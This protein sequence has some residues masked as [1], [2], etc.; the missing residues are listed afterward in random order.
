MNIL[1]FT[2]DDFDSLINYR[3]INTDL[4]REFQ[5]HNHRIFVISP[6]ERK[7]GFKT[8]IVKENKAIILKPKIGNIQKTNLI[9]KGISTLTIG[10]I[11][12]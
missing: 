10:S 11:L 2:L 7:K 5:K 12:I 8:R 9:E 6:S 1:Y 4:L 3:S